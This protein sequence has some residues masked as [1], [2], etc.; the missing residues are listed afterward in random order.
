MSNEFR[1]H[2]LELREVKV[3]HNAEFWRRQIY[4]EKEHQKPE[5]GTLFL[6]LP[7]TKPRMYKWG[8]IPAGLTENDGYAVNR[9]LL[10][11]H[12]R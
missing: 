7:N 9:M 4:T 11:N 2:R 10:R 1:R 6:S 3:S 8:K 5:K 12:T